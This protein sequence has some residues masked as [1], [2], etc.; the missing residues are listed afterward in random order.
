MVGTSARL[1]RLL[2][3][4]QR[5]AV[6]SGEQLSERLEVD[7][8][9]VRRD[10]DRLR[11]L[12]YMVHATA[13][14]GGGYQLGAGETVPPLLLSDEEAV[15]VAAG[16]LTVSA[17]AR[18]GFEQ[19]ALGTLT[20][21]EQL[22]PPRLKRRLQALSKATDSLGRGEL[23]SINTAILL[24]LAMACHQHEEVTIR[25]NDREGKV[26]RRTIEPH[27]LVT[28]GRTWYVPSWDTGRLDWR[29]F[30]VDRIESIAGTGR[31]FTPRRIPK[32]AAAF[33]AESV[34]TNQYRFRA[35]LYMHASAAEVESQIPPTIG[36]VEAI[37]EKS[38]ILHTGG[39]C[40]DQLSRYLMLI[41]AEFEVLDPP[42][43]REQFSELG[44]RC[45]RMASGMRSHSSE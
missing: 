25:Y 20:K 43:L 31:R 10:I 6:W 45:L 29:T 41:R 23:Q 37:D 18:P 8:R 5:R 7:V 44:R 21:L 38:C 28:A 4:L 33:V 17:G 34:S 15:T 19:S 9:T 39:N 26:T 42:E 40:L 35:R 13:G 14:V 22:L 30:R 12:G 11:S 2:S 3:L 27:R 1:L 16:L 24:D 36:R 32:G